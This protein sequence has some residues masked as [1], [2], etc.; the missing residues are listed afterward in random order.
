MENF[1]RIEIHY[2][3]NVQGVG[4]RFRARN[5]AQDFDLTGFVRNLGDGR[6]HLVAEG[7]KEDLISF[8]REIDQTMERYVRDKS[9][10][11]TKANNQFVTFDIRA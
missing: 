7:E 10:V 2:V 3:G 9:V 5:I 6:V 1:R 4:F 11:W 8:L